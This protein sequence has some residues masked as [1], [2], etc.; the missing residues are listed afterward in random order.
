MNLFHLEY[1]NKRGMVFLCN[2][3]GGDE[4]EMVQDIVSQVG[5]IRVISLYRMSE[6]HR[7]T[8]T[9][10]KG[11]IESSMMKEPQRGKGRPRKLD[12]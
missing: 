11:I 12:F 8:D 10:R 7:I 4:R 2:V 3:V 6:V 9:I 5:Q 1:E